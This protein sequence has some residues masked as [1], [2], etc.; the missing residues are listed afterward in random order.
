MDPGFKKIPIL[1]KKKKKSKRTVYGPVLI[2]SLAVRNI[3]N[4][5]KAMR[6]TYFYRFCKDYNANFSGFYK[7][8]DGLEAS[9]FHG[10]LRIIFTELTHL[11]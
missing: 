3:L 7:F 8:L 4:H 1:K 5:L 6:T 10:S 11:H 2:K 9:Y